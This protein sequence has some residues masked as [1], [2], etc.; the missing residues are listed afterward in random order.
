MWP[1][2]T[3]TWLRLATVRC[4]CIRPSMTAHL[5]RQDAAKP[6]AGIAAV[7]ALE[8]MR[9]SWRQRELTT[10]VYP[11]RSVWCGFR[12]HR[13]RQNACSQVP[14]VLSTEVGNDTNNW[15][16]R[17]AVSCRQTDNGTVEP[18]LYFRAFGR[19][20]WHRLASCVSLHRWM[21]PGGVGSGRFGADVVVTDPVSCPGRQ[22]TPVPRKGRL[23]RH[24]YTTV[25]TCC[26]ARLPSH[27][28]RR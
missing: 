20:D 8:W 13:R 16:P 12:F 22:A 9:V 10:A 28:E 6:I 1:T 18:R 5:Q 3:D 11:S 24:Y 21:C 4:S 14:S 7:P 23:T 25:W 2:D 27:D 17:T 15:R 19:S 26:V